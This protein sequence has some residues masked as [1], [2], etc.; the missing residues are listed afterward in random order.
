MLI[1]KI[2]SILRGKPLVCYI[3]D[4]TDNL[5]ISRSNKKDIW[6]SLIKKLENIILKKCDYIFTI[7]DSL[8][9]WLYNLK[10]DRRRIKTINYGI[11]PSRL[12][13]IIPKEEFYNRFKISPE[14]IKIIYA[15]GNHLHHGLHLLL[16]NVNDLCEKYNKIE[17]IIATNF[18]KES[19]I[20]YKKCVKFLGFIDFSMYVCLINYSDIL[21]CP[22]DPK[23]P[24]VSVVTNKLIQFMITGNAIVATNVGVIPRII[25]TR[26]NGI[27]VK[28]TPV[29]L[30]KGIE[31]LINNNDLRRKYGRNSKK[32]AL[33][34]LDWNKNLKKILNILIKL[35]HKYLN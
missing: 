34:Y 20:N 1:G 22:P 17:I 30:I 26:E 19:M 14:K 9:E 15:G 23:Y 10:I 18:K 27:V 28:R 6:F 8:C 11:D 33:K 24:Y 35:N 25:K 21:N 12:T 29:E 5:R 31:T 7:D 16:E 2:I 3:V 32:Y 4:N 13:P